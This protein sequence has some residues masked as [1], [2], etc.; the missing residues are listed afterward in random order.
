MNDLIA[1]LKK[2]LE[3]ER[4]ARHEAERIAETVT[5]ELYAL[6]RMKAEFISL[7]SHELRTPLTAIL[8]FTRSLGRAELR[9]D[10]KVLVDAL[11]AIERN[12]ER[13]R[14]LVDQ[15]LSSSLFQQFDSPVQLEAIDFRELAERV[16][17]EIGLRRVTLELDIDPSMPTVLSDPLMLAQVLRSLVDNAAKFSPGGGRCTVGARVE[18]STL[19]FWVQDQGIGMGRDQIDHVFEPFWQ[20]D[21]S[22]TRRFGGV[23]LGLHLARRIVHILGGDISVES[24]AGKGTR[25]MVSVRAGARAAGGE[26]E[27]G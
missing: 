24:E 13:L 4:R 16:C 2:R 7:V 17:S 23:G 21:P 19:Q 3:R 8:G 12:A 18:D 5:G 22:T 27:V 26:A 10:E 9:A 11:E 15:L 14:S 20:A 1:T 6:N 25:F